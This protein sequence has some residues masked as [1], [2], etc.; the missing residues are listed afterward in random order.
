MHKKILN[1]LLYIFWYLPGI[2]LCFIVFRLLNRTKIKGKENIPKK[3]G[4]LIMAN[5]VSALDSWL[6]GYIFF[7]RP[8]F[9]PAKAEL[10]RNPLLS[11]L[12]RGWRAFPVVRGRYNVAVMEKIVELAKDNIVVLHPEG[13]RSLNGEIGQGR[14]GV[15]KII[16]ESSSPV[17]PIC[18]IGMEKFLPVGKRFPSFFKSLKIIIGRSIDFSRYKSLKPSKEIYKIIVDNLMDEI[19]KL[20]TS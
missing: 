3:G 8:V 19:K 18:T 17:I 13:T 10:F 20:K 1:F 16:Y 4:M 15:G 7:P 14:R 11:I 12:L 6:I 2:F 9:F 5:H